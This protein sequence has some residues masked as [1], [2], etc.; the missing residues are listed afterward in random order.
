[1]LLLHLSVSWGPHVYFK[2]LQL[3][4]GV[5][6]AYID[7]VLEIYSFVL[8]TFFRSN[9]HIVY[10]ALK[11]SEPTL[12]KYWQLSNKIMSVDSVVFNK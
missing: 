8:Q 4:K 5:Y 2:V 1:M 10:C 11:L 3:I 7:K 9:Q 6:S 12:S